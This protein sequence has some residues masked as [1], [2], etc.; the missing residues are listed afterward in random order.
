VAVCGSGRRARL[1]ELNN[2]APELAER[3]RPYAHGE[4]HPTFSRAG[5]DPQYLAR[6]A[7]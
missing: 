7:E 1:A 2:T 3:C 6:V 4:P 5:N